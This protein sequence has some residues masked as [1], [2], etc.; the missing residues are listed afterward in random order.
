MTLPFIADVAGGALGAWSAAQNNRMQREMQREQMAFQERMSNTAHQREVADLRA[1]GLNPM[2]S[3]MRG[4]GASTPGGAGAP[5]VQD[6]GG[7]IVQGIRSAARAEGAIAQLNRRALAA[8]VKYADVMAYD[9]AKRIG[10]E[11]QVAEQKAEQERINT[12]QMSFDLQN[13]PLRRELEWNLM[14]G[15]AFSAMSSG[16]YQEAGVD[17]Q[18]AISELGRMVMPWLRQA[19]EGHSQLVPAWSRMMNWALRGGPLGEAYRRLNQSNS[20]R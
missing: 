20:R 7:P 8:T 3:A 18:R 13:L 9:T 15:Q 10:Y 11:H 5:A 6:V 1:A 17:R 12:A 19:T 2:L 4:G 16:R 14:R